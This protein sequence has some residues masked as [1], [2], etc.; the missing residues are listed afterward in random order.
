[1]K[2]IQYCEDS[3]VTVLIEMKSS[4]M[5]NLLG[6]LLKWIALPH[7][8]TFKRL[9]IAYVYTDNACHLHAMTAARTLY[10]LYTV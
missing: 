3:I 8:D 2:L 1:M 6:D 4:F 10:V 9:T 7:F 5:T